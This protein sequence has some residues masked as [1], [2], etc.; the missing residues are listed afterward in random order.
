MLPSSSRDANR[1][2]VDPSPP[3]TPQSRPQARPTPRPISRGTASARWERQSGHAPDDSHVS[4]QP[5][6]GIQIWRYERLQH[7]RYLRQPA[8]WMQ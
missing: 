5:N 1:T 7:L 6:V 3:A 2:T 4:I 8:F